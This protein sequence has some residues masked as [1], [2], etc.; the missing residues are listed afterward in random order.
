MQP[1]LKSRVVSALA[2]GGVALALTWFGGAPFRIMA[3]IAA[4]LI[5]HEWTAITGA[6]RASLPAYVVGWAAIGTVATATIAG[7]GEAGVVTIVLG[8]PAVLVLAFLS[9][10][11]LWLSAWLGLGIVYAGF[12][13]LAVAEIRDDAAVGLIATA[14]LF[15][16]VWGTDIFAYFCGRA[17]GGPRLAPG[18]SPGKTWSGAIFGMLAGIAAGT[19]IALA[20]LEKGGLWIPALAA[21]LSIL[22]QLGDLFES[23]MKRRFAVKDS[24]RI[25]PG[26]GGVMD[27]LDGLVFAALAAFLVSLWSARSVPYVDGGLPIA[28][29]LLGL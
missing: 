2:L 19:G 17:I 20:T 12:A 3:A 26:H 6:R 16:I 14:Y 18:I 22:S 4:L 25:I 29:S 7:A 27:R 5:Y 9:S 21:I 28:V 13:G 1:E 8:A 15:A 11:G 23:F 10:A 24:G